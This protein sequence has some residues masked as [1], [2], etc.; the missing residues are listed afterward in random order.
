MPSGLPPL[1]TFLL[2]SALL[3]RG[4]GFPPSLMAGRILTIMLY[5]ATTWSASRFAIK[6]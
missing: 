3:R 1:P 6:P 5:V 4:V 2:I